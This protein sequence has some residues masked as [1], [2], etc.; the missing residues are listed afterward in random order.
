V[1]TAL[2]SRKNCKSIKLQVNKSQR[3]CTVSSC[4]N[5]RTL[6]SHFFGQKFRE[7]NVFTK[8]ITEEL[9]WRNI[10]LVRVNVSFYHTVS[11]EIT[12]I[13]SYAFLATHLLNKLPKSWFDGIFL[14]VRVNFSFFHSV[15]GKVFWNAITL[16]NFREINTLVPYLVKLLIW[17]KK[18][19]FFR[20]NRDRVL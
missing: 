4:G 17:R 12:E 19:W 20:T 11:W 8:E 7:T 10:F 6:L 14:W 3:V 2:I 9:I 1:K 18:C 13:Y 15:G 5:Y 16:K